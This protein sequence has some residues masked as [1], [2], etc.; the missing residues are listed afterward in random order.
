MTH[1]GLKHCIRSS[2]AI[3]H[4]SLGSKAHPLLSHE[5]QLQYC[6]WV[7]RMWVFGV[8]IL[9]VCL[10]SVCNGTLALK[11]TVQTLQQLCVLLEYPSARATPLNEYIVTHTGIYVQ[12]WVCVFCD[13]PVFLRERANK[14]VH[15]SETAAQAAYASCSLTDPSTKLICIMSHVSL[16][17]VISNTMIWIQGYCCYFFVS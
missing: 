16:L 14:D 12:D 9:R 1:L 11:W 8:F 6:C 13:F 17:E 3:P 4:H 10:Q 2:H 5:K 15:I 7:K